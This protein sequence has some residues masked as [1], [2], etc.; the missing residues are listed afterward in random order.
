MRK[1]V[2]KIRLMRRK[3]LMRRIRLELAIWGIDSRYLTDKQIEDGIVKF[4]RLISQ[5][6]LT[7][8]E[9][10]EGIYLIINSK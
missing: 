1:I 6:G 4:A 10:I 3:K 7:A 5:T 2:E 9:A 8:K